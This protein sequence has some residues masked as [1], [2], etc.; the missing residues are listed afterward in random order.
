MGGIAEMTKAHLTSFHICWAAVGAMSLNNGSVRS[1]DA[2][3]GGGGSGSG[4]SRKSLPDPIADIS[5][6]IL[7]R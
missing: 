5:P 2:E 7:G 3:F 1:A 4:G 6:G